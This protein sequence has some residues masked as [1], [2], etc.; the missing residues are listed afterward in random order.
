MNA[1]PES[2]RGVAAARPRRTEAT[3]VL[4]SRLSSIATFEGFV[5]GLGFLDAPER[6]RL[7][8]SGGEIL[9]NIVKHAY[10]VLGDTVVL[11]A[12][13]RRPGGPLLLGFYFRSP[14]FAAFAAK[15]AEGSSEPLFDPAHRRWRG[16]GLA[17]CRNLARKVSFRPGL[18]MDRIFLEFGGREGGS[19]KEAI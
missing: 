4:E 16:I 8:I 17:M 10:P 9:D 3:I 13:R 11:R 2:G 19:K 15:E 1:G 5:E 14:A 7:T 12:S 18:R 6:D